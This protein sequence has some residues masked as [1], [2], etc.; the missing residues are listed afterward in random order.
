MNKYEKAIREA[1]LDLGLAEEH[2][3][4][5]QQRAAKSAQRWQNKIDDAS[6]KIASA[7]LVLK[8]AERAED[9]DTINTIR[10]QVWPLAERLNEH[11]YNFPL[12][13]QVNALHGKGL[14]AGDRLGG[15]NRAWNMPF[16]PLYRVISMMTE[17]PLTTRP[18][19]VMQAMGLCDEHGERFYVE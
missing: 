19:S 16:V 5:M 14:P 10:D 3:R 18:R 13:D 12:Q 4:D 15:G 9:A 11:L 8:R 7:R 2:H 17:G 1:R 6:S